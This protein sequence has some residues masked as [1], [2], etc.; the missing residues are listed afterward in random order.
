MSDQPPTIYDELKAARE[1]IRDLTEELLEAKADQSEL[2]LGFRE[3]LIACSDLH[4]NLP[5]TE[6]VDEIAGPL[7][8]INSTLDEWLGQLDEEE[9]NHE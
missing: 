5:N 8:I 7:K 6:W 9:V 1:V 4:D 2:A 3:L